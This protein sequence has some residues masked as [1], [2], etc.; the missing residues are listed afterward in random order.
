LN[1]AIESIYSSLERDNDG[2]DAHIETLKKLMIGKGLSV[3]QINPARLPQPNRQGRKLMQS[4]FKKRGVTVEF[5]NS[6]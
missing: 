3:V 6:L 1:D 2:L 5:A 4:Y